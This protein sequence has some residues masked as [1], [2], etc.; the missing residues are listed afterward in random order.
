MK[1]TIGLSYAPENEPKFRMYTEAL[2]HAA[3]SLGYE[4]EV[5]A[6]DATPSLVSQIDG[7]VFTGGHDVYPERYGKAE[8]T[9]FCHDLDA[10]RDEHEFALATAADEKKL[11]VLG[12]CRGLQLL[13]VHYGGTLIVDLER[14]GYGSHSKVKI[15]DGLVDREHEVHVEP[16]TTL[17]RLTRT[18]E[19]PIASAHHQVI[20]K[21]A[22]GMQISARSSGDEVIEAIEWADPK[23]KP[24]FI[25]VQW[26]PERMAYEKPLAGE[27]FEGF[28]TEVAMHKLLKERLK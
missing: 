8:E 10:E 16:G 2:T 1:L 25:A 20:D 18:A 19:A 11:P 13:N 24:Y 6:L 28:L 15:E 4:L 17:K 21:L 12:I 27:L 23:N 3:E 9:E 14:A 26:H 7:I 5:I 22:P